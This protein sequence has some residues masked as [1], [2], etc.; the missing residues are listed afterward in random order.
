MK[1]FSVSISKFVSVIEIE[2]YK[3]VITSPILYNFWFSLIS[4]SESFFSVIEIPEAVRG[5]GIHHH[6]ARLSLI[7]VSQTRR[8]SLLCAMCIE[9]VIT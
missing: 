6:L 4:M 7:L 5:F 8:D 2:K 3:I 1:I 9:R